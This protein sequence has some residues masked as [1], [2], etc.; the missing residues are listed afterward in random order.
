MQLTALCRFAGQAA[1][2]RPR[3][4]AISTNKTGNIERAGDFKVGKQF[5]RKRFTAFLA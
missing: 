2:T 1:I 5:P 4:L 3:Y